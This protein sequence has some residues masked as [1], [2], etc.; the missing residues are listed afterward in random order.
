MTSLRVAAAYPSRLDPDDAA[1]Y[2][3]KALNRPPNDSS[4]ERP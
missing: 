1:G 2:L 3:P 4:D